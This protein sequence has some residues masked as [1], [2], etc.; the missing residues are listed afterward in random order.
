MPFGQCTE[1]KVHQLYPNSTSRERSLDGLATPVSPEINTCDVENDRGGK[2]QL[3]YYP[4]S[5]E[6]SPRQNLSEVK[7][8]N[9]VQGTPAWES[10]IAVGWRN[11]RP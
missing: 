5:V 11:I 8:I 6:I 9:V 7:A 10:T 2:Y 1:A 4:D 3:L